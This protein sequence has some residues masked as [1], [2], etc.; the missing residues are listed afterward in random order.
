M[1]EIMFTPDEIAMFERI[2]K[3]DFYGAHSFVRN[4]KKQGFMTP[5]QKQAIQ[6]MN[7]SIRPWSSRN[8]RRKPYN[9]WDHDDLYE[10]WDGI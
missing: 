7:N 5:K 1:G 6:N 9:G 4:V 2:E 10:G 8:Y 3:S